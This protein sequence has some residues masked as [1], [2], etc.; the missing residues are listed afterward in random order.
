MVCMNLALA[1]EF[2]ALATDNGHCIVTEYFAYV[3]R[4]PMLR[5]AKVSYA[6]CVNLTTGCFLS[7]SGA[8]GHW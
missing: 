6:L 8:N 2:K 7:S 5:L 3:P 4:L 1:S